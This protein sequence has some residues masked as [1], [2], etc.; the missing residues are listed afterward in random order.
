MLLAFTTGAVAVG[1]VA[2]TT[3]K[4]TQKFDTRFDCANVAPGSLFTSLAGGFGGTLSL[5]P[6]THQAEVDPY[7]KLPG[8]G[9]SHCDYYEPADYDASPTSEGPAE[10]TVL[11][12]QAAVNFYKSDHAAAVGGV[13][14]TGLKAQN[15]NA[16]IDPRQCGPV[17]VSGIGDQAYEAANYIAVLRGKVFLAVALA[18]AVNS[19]GQR[20]MVP[21]DL[22]QSIVTAL[23]ARLPSK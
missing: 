6:A 3:P 17:P 23:L 18:P 7:I 12:G 15:P 14:C 20:V 1:A 11:Y 13:T 22:L 9:I 2:A 10:V 21:A 4:K 16:V 5:K 19:T 8:S